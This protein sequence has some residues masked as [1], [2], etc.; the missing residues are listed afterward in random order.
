VKSGERATVGAL[1]AAGAAIWIGIVFLV[2]STFGLVRFDH[3]GGTFGVSA[4]TD[5]AYCSVEIGH[6][7]T[8]ERAA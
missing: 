3:Y 5:S 7:P 6:F 2:L 8:C 1:I 4:G